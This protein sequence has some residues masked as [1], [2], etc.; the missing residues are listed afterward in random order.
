DG[1]LDEDDGNCLL[2]PIAGGTGALGAGA[3]AWS[4]SAGL[5]FRAAGDLSAAAGL[6]AGVDGALC[7]DG[8]GSGDCG[9]G[10]ARARTRGGDWPVR[11]AF[12][13]QSGMVA[14]VLRHASDRAGAG[15]HY[16][17]GGVAGGGDRA[18]LARAAGGGG[19]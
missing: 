14:S 2:W 13:A 7:A 11:A 9:F 1:V 8:R 12:P 18:V 5:S 6:S 4:Q 17:H 15:H 10:A 16:R 3:G 19:F